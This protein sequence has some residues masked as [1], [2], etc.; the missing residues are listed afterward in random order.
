[1]DELAVLLKKG[2]LE[3]LEKLASLDPVLR[4]LAQAITKAALSTKEMGNLFFLAKWKSPTSKFAEALRT[5]FYLLAL[6]E[7]SPSCRGIIGF[8][9]WL[10]KEDPVWVEELLKTHVAAALKDKTTY[11]YGEVVGDYHRVDL[12]I[13]CMQKT[14]VAPLDLLGRMGYGVQKGDMRSSIGHG[15]WTNVVKKE[16]IDRALAI[17][18]GDSWPSAPWLIALWDEIDACEDMELIK[19]KWLPKLFKTRNVP[20]QGTPSGFSP[21]SAR[22]SRLQDGSSVP[23]KQRTPRPFRSTRHTLSL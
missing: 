3:Q 12:I 15:A 4:I 16:G 5:R 7:P 1:M 21:G 14:L 9:R 6:P 8:L 18:G 10:P 22:T 13:T 11:G 20:G 19:T 23:A 17:R 2:D